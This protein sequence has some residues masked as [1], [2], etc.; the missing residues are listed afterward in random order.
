MDDGRPAALM[1]VGSVSTKRRVDL[2]GRALYNSTDAHGGLPAVVLRGSGGAQGRRSP[3]LERSSRQRAGG[4]AG[5]PRPGR[6]ERS[7]GITPAGEIHVGAAPGAGPHE[8]ALVGCRRWRGQGAPVW[9]QA[10]WIEQSW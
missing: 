9:L 6:C 2:P 1:E 4:G 3:T 8:V 5:T 7:K 10:I